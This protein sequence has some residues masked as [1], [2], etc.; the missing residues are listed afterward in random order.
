MSQCDISLGRFFS[1]RH[2][3]TPKPSYGVRNTA[4]SPFAG[5]LLDGRTFQ[6]LAMVTAWA[7][8]FTVSLTSTLKLPVS[9]GATCLA[10]RMVV[11][12]QP[13]AILCQC[14]MIFHSTE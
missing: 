9:T 2:S 4:V 11:L 1:T 13:H 10:V 8:F 5:G 12:K 7:L 14:A 3:C 6:E